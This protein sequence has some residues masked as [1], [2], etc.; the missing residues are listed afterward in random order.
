MSHHFKYREKLYAI[1][2]VLF[3]CGL[4]ASISYV[5]LIKPLGALFREL[6]SRSIGLCRCLDRW[7]SLGEI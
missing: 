5:Q 1:L 3:N 2:S 6:D 7:I 4:I